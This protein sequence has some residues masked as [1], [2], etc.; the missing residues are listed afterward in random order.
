MQH[1]PPV[2]AGL[3]LHV[4]FFCD[5]KDTAPPAPIE[6]HEMSRLLLQRLLVLEVALQR[7]AELR[8]AQAPLQ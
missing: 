5:A 2:S 8:T 4:A 3:T 7:V 1:R 6:P